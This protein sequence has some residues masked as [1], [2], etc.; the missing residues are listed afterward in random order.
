MWQVCSV[1]FSN[2]VRA[3]G[4]K[5]LPSTHAALLLKYLFFPSSP[6]NM[7]C[8]IAGHQGAGGG[9]G[10]D[11]KLNKEAAHGYLVEVLN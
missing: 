7:E 3:R 4:G 2:Y 9:G 5:G 10:G 6:I 1:G 11:G 8:L